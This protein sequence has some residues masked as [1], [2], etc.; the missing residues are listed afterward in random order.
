MPVQVSAL[1]SIQTGKDT[2]EDA[3]S[4]EFVASLRFS[5]TFIRQFPSL[6]VGLRTNPPHHTIAIR[7]NRS[8]MR[9]GA[10]LSW[11]DDDR[12]MWSAIF[13]LLGR[14]PCSQATVRAQ[15][16]VAQARSASG[17]SH[18]PGYSHEYQP[19]GAVLEFL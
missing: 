17:L 9:S 10:K 12:H 13:A 18:W 5:G 2:E 1:L 6:L 3:V 4:M 8:A 14:V 15:S 16:A 11:G 19:A 7:R